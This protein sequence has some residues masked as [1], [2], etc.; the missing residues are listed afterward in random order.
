MKTLKVTKAQADVLD[1]ALTGMIDSAVCS[2]EVDED[3]GYTEEQ[4][5]RFVEPLKWVKRGDISI[6][7]SST[8]DLSKTNDDA[9]EE[10]I[11]RLGTQLVDMAQAEGSTDGHNNKYA[12]IGMCRRLVDR[13][14][15]VWEE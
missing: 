6:H 15:R 9:I 1:W 10:L 3:I 8:L 14:Q 5:P 2:K 12:T 13:I 7:I 11:Y 4:I